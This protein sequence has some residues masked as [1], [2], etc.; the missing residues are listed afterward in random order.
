VA[1]PSGPTMPVVNLTL[2]P[3]EALQVATVTRAARAD[4]TIPNRL[5]PWPSPAIALELLD[6]Q[7]NVSTLE[8]RAQPGWYEVRLDVESGH[9]YRLQGEIDGRRISAITTIP[10]SFSV[11]VPARDTIQIG[12]GT[13]GAFYFRVPYLFEAVGA[14]GFACVLRD[15]QGNSLS[16]TVGIGPTGELAMQY[17]SGLQ[18]VWLLAYNADAANWLLHTTPI[19]NVTGALGGFGAALVVRRWVLLP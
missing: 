15:T 1:S 12:D 4:S 8:P 18:Q 7:G 2:I 9:T 16:C 6:D 14:G 10:P 17:Q 5:V 13:V 19:T 3:G 11:V